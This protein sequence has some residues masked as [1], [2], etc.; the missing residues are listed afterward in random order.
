MKQFFLAAL[1]LFSMSAAYAGKSMLMH[2][3]FDSDSG[4]GPSN[5]DGTIDTSKGC[6]LPI[7]N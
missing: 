4:S 2:V 1:I 3:Y 6:P 7:L 5:C